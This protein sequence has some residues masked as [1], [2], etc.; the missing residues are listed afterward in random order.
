VAEELEVGDRGRTFAGSLK[1]CDS[2]KA[3]VVSRETLSRTYEEN[4]Y[5][6]AEGRCCAMKMSPSQTSISEKVWLLLTI[7][8]SLSAG[9]DS[10]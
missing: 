5:S 7:S 8:T 1:S 2:G 4:T 6:A 10:R 3:V 9:Y